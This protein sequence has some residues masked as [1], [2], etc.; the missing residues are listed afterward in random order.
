MFLSD[1]AQHDSATASSD[2]PADGA[3]TDTPATAPDLDR[4]DLPLVELPTDF[5]LPPLDLTS[6]AD[7]PLVVLDTDAMAA[8]HAPHDPDASADATYDDDTHD[9]TRPPDV[10]LD[11]DAALTAASSLSE[12]L[13]EQE[14]RRAAELQADA[15]AAR[16]AAMPRVYFPAPPLDTLKRGRLPSVVSGLALI[17]IGIWLSYTL[18]T[19]RA[20]PSAE[21][22]VLV[23]G[24]AVLATLLAHWLANGRWAR[25]TLFA[26]LV[27]ALG[28]AAVWLALTQAALSPALIPLLVAAFGGALLLSGALAR[29]LSRA[30]MGGGAVLLLGG[31]AVVLLNSAFPAVIAAI[32]AFWFVPL[33]VLALLLLTSVFRRA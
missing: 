23:I 16:L 7:L 17:G 3:N 2:T 33:I 24:G 31:G 1:D 32:S 21:L 27:L 30:A 15:E 8:M 13:A 4:V 22:L 19:S 6:T 20:L 5:D 9:S 11:V 29:P 18:A 25:G 26:A 28:G 12:I 10:P 14:A